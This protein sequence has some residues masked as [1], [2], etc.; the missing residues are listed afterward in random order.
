[1][2]NTG[3]ELSLTLQVSLIIAGK[4]MPGY[5]INYQGRNTFTYNGNTYPDI[6]VLQMRQMTH[7]DFLARLT[8]FKAYVESIELGLTIDISGAYR[9]NLT[10]CPID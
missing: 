10:S 1:M 2:A 4:I 7:N 8:D 3:Y 6:T 9:E 5:P